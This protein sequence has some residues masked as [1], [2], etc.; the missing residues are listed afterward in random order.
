[1][2]DYFAWEWGNALFVVLDPF[3]YTRESKADENWGMTLGDDQYRWL[4]KTLE[5]SKKAFKFVFIHH[6]VGGKVRDVRGGVAAAPYMEWGGKNLDD[7]DG[8][9]KHRPGWALPLHQLFVKTGVSAIFH[10]HDHL[11]V[12]EELDG[13]IYQEVPQPGHPSGGTRSAE[14]YGYTGVILGSSGYLRVTVSPVEARVDYVRSIVPG[15]TRD[16]MKNASVEHS[17]TIKPRAH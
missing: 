10:G 13:I 16:D 2:Q 17:Y 7:S 11:Y 14:E 12:K 9:A 5:S 1:L 15:I 3:W 4:T 8:F 6:L